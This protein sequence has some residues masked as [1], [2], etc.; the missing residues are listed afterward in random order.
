M[1]ADDSTPHPATCPAD[2]TNAEKQAQRFKTHAVASPETPAFQESLPA[3][4]PKLKLS[5]DAMSLNIIRLTNSKTY[6]VPHD[7]EK[8][9]TRSYYTHAHSPPSAFKA[10]SLLA[11]DWPICCA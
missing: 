2:G 6:H 3:T 10:N 4:A 8:E 5:E 7:T 1:A 11:I 9:F